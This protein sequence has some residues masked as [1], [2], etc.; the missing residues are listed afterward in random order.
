MLAL[1]CC[2]LAGVDFDEKSFDNIPDI[3]IFT[4]Q[5]GASAYELARSDGNCAYCKLRP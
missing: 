1:F 3:G 2:V 5:M 4:Y